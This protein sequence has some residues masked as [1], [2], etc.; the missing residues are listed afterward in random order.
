VYF[1]GAMLLTCT[2]HFSLYP[3]IYQ[4]YEDNGELTYKLTGKNNFQ[5]YDVN[6]VPVVPATADIST[7]S[8]G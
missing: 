6:G 4:D 1:K 7:S 8:S 3:V 5:N 2:A